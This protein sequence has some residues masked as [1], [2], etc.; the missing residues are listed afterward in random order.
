MKKWIIYNFI[1][2]FAVYWLSNLLL[3]FPWSFNPTFG[4]I[5]MLTLGTTLWAV[6]SYFC[7]I[8][9]PEKKIIKGALINAF[10]LLFSAIIMDFVF[11]GIIRNAMEELYHITTLYGYVF[12]LILPII[13]AI[14][15]RK[16]ITENDKELTRPLFIKAATLGIFCLAQLILIIILDINI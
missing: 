8:Y 12:L 2:A 4:M 6:A 3:W 13:I 7:L 15:F 10:I 16:K 14:L 11:F 9:F 5:L 1:V